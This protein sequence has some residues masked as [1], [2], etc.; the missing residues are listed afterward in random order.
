MN[1]RYLGRQKT[2]HLGQWPFVGLAAAR[3]RRDE[4]RKQLASKLDP[5]AEK[6]FEVL[7]RKNRCEQL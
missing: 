1:Y 6:R 3:E 2:L 5:A 7:T 4:A